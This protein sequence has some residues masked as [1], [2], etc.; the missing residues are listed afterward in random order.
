M[1]D[2]MNPAG[3][4]FIY[5]SCIHGL[6]GIQNHWLEIPR[7]A[8]RWRLIPA[9]NVKFFLSF[10]QIPNLT[11]H[12]NSYK[13]QIWKPLISVRW[14]NN[15]ISFE[16][17]INKMLCINKILPSPFYCYGLCSLIPSFWWLIINYLISL[18]LFNLPSHKKIYWHHDCNICWS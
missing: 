17:I 13:R 14:Q 2:F 1:S 8:G 3:F 5:K 12:R 10:L 6:F 9:G 16:M 15:Y 18:L 11:P 4:W 7:V